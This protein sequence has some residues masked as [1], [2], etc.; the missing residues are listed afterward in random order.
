MA[1]MEVGIPLA[2]KGR[3]PHRKSGRSPAHAG[4]TWDVSGHDLLPALRDLRI[5]YARHRRRRCLIPSTSPGTSGRRFPAAMRTI[6]H[7]GHFAF[8]ECPEEVLRST[9]GLRGRRPSVKR[10]AISGAA[11]LARKK[12]VLRNAIRFVLLLLFA[13]SL[14]AAQATPKRRVYD[15]D[16]RIR[17][18]MRRLSGTSW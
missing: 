3:D 7:G 18:S 1:T 8:L 10:R 17:I 14:A 13:P 4:E 2:G 16:R 5:R 12:P 9:G 15:D 11:N 6:H